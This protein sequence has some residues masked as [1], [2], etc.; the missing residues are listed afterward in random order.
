MAF[1]D[2]KAIMSSGGSGSPINMRSFLPRLGI[3]S[4]FRGSPAARIFRLD[5]TRYGGDKPD[6]D[7]VKVEITIKDNKTGDYLDIPVIP[8]IISYRDGDTKYDVFSVVNLGDV[9]FPS[10]VALDGLS[11]SC[12][13]PGRYDPGYCRKVELLKPTQYRNILSTWKDKGTPLQ[14][15]I[16]AFDI[17]KS[18]TVKNFTWD[19]KGFEG[20]LYY[21]VEFQEDKKVEPKEVAVGGTAQDPANQTAEDRPPA[22]ADEVKDGETPVSSEDW[23]DAGASA[24]KDEVVDTGDWRDAGASARQDTTAYMGDLKQSE[25]SEATKTTN[26]DV[27]RYGGD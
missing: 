7:R 9:A 8:E 6:L 15:I 2:M 14:V 11:W 12:F 13:F 17:N 22:P 16:P 1:F 4:V 24:R 20:D 26:E 27:L 5:Y 18:M 25:Y 19:G 10:G 3:D 23:R 21:T